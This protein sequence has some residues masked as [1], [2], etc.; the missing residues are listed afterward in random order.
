MPCHVISGYDKCK[1]CPWNIQECLMY[2]GHDTEDND[3]E[4]TNWILQFIN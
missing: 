2:A 1:Q 3:E 4:M